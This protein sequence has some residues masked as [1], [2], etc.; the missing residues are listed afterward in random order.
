MKKLLAL[1]LIIFLG[2][3][4]FSQIKTYTYESYGIINKHTNNTVLTVPEKL[5][6][7]KSGELKFF[8]QC[9][10]PNLKGK[11]VF[12]FSVEYK[13]YSDLNKNYVYVGECVQEGINMENCMILSPNKLDIFL[14][15]VGRTKEDEGFDKRLSFLAIIVNKDKDFYH[16]FP[17]KNIID[18]NS[19]LDINK[20]PDKE[21]REVLEIS[22]LNKEKEQEQ[23]KINNIEKIKEVLSEVNIEQKVSQIKTE[24]ENHYKSLLKDKMTNI[25]ARDLL[26]LKD[27]TTT[28]SLSGE[29]ILHID[30]NKEIEIIKK[31]V[32]CT[33]ANYSF[34]ISDDESSF[35]NREALQQKD[36]YA[37]EYKIGE[38]TYYT[39]NNDIFTDNYKINKNLSLEIKTIG[40]N[41][42]N[43]KFKYYTNES[44]SFANEKVI[45]KI[46]E[47]WC[48]E[49]IK[50]N[51][52]YFINSIMIDDELTCRILNLD[53]QT[54]EYLKQRFKIGLMN[55]Y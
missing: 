20:I 53:R 9:F 26:A 13:G 7:R 18:S 25:S 17:I 19:K 34:N 29:F 24:I 6:I 12:T 38:Y 30:K 3:N 44:I 21:K 54:K 47:N 52:L 55:R 36:I 37:D 31:V 48:A 39:L 40:V 16:F 43:G 5:V 10:D 51:G 1:L 11:P 35:I 41:F 49:N 33:D 46:V 23:N 15:G 28:I 50:T 14:K 42:K 2:L 22:H 27:Y 4:V 32:N 8:I 45:P